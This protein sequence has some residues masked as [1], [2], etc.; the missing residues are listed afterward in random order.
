[1]NDTM[2]LLLIKVGINLVTHVA[3]KIL[4]KTRVTYPQTRILNRVFLRLT[5]AFNTELAAK[6]RGLEDHNFQRLL[7]T[8]L[9]ALAYISEKDRYYRQWLGLLVLLVEE[10]VAR[11][12][13][14]VGRDEFVALVQAQWRLNWE[15]LSED[16]YQARRDDLFPVLL[17]DFLQNLA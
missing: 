17:T 15:V 9:H 5:K 8:S 14:R 3:S 4:P 10:E 13:Q 2:K 6:R 1:M 12:R 7:E 11:E 16:L